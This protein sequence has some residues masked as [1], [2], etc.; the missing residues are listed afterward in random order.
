[1]TRRSICTHSLIAPLARS[2]TSYAQT[3]DDAERRAE[4][5]AD[6]ER[7]RV[8]QT[9][10]AIHRVGCEHVYALSVE[11][12]RGDAIVFGAS[13]VASG[14]SFAR[15]RESPWPLEFESDIVDAVFDNAHGNLLLAGAD[16]LVRRYRRGSFDVLTTYPDDA[17]WAETRVRSIAV[18]PDGTRLVI[19]G[20][21]HG[22]RVFDLETGQELAA[23]AADSGG[24]G[25][26]IYLADGTLLVGANDG[27]MLRV[28]SDAITTADTITTVTA[29]PL[30][31]TTAGEGQ[32]SVVAADGV[33]TVHSLDGGESTVSGRPLDGPIAAAAGGVDPFGAPRLLLADQ[34]GR[35][36]LVDATTLEWIA[37][38][39]S[40][41]GELTA[42]AL[43]PYAVFAVTAF[44]GGELHRWNL[45]RLGDEKAASPQGIDA[46]ATLVAD[47]QYKEALARL[48]RLR[49]PIEQRRIDEFLAAL[50]PAPEGWSVSDEEWNAAPAVEGRRSYSRPD[51]AEVLLD[52]TE[53]VPADDVQDFLSELEDPRAP[54]GYVQGIPAMLQM[55]E[56][57]N[58]RGTMAMM[59][60]P[61]GST[62]NQ[63]RLGLRITTSGVDLSVFQ[64]QFLEQIDATGLLELTSV[65]RP[66]P[67]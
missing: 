62:G 29:R 34:H 43:D 1:M 59:I 11:T 42:I 65:D 12:M 41:T 26:A 54:K 57:Q 58:G 24:A 20:D 61:G 39:P 16:G 33:V 44:R 56:G 66:A 27:R 18:S 31:L 15:E 4:I 63:S 64:R 52:L 8:E 19:A 45:L 28:R 6:F 53:S 32:I 3:P 55:P 46:I 67:A 17:F 35:G 37:E 60:P 14:V 10:E 40:G 22:A 51:G 23:H 25:A 48:A 38:I 47:G 21:A 13:G 49:R 2:A 50:P 30:L 7:I 9:T 5:E 36:V